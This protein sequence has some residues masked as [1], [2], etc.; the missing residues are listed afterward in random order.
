MFKILKDYPNV[1]LPETIDLHLSKFEFVFNPSYC[2]I[3]NYNFLALR[4]CED[5]TS[6]IQSFLYKWLESD[7]IDILNLSK[8]CT[9]EFDINK[10]ADPKLVVLDND[11]YCTFNTGHTKG[12][13]NQIFITPIKDFQNLRVKECI[14]NKRNAI[15]KNWSF[16]MKNDVLHCL[17]GLDPLKVLKVSREESKYIIFEEVDT[18][19][20]IGINASIGTQ[21]SSLGGNQYF[22]M[23]HDKKIF[24][25][26]RIYFGIP[27]VFNKENYSLQKTS[28]SL[29]INSIETLFGNKF[30]FNRNLIS[31]TYFSGC[32]VDEETIILSYGINDAA[33]KIVKVPKKNL[34]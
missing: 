30:K 14:Y 9:V 2:R 34:L 16:F 1:Q 26:K 18:T 21:L 13:S 28:K 32:N 29:F 25:G 20:N 4:V 6:D 12:S 31:C 27:L 7:S 22:F 3:N 8:Y 17:Y 19:T 33:M 15:E 23:A 24:R 5:R 10:V 11:I